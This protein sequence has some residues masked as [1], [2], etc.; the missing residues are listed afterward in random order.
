MTGDVRELGRDHDGRG[1]RGIRGIFH[2]PSHVVPCVLSH[3]QELCLPLLTSLNQCIQCFPTLRSFPSTPVGLQ[4]SVVLCQ[5]SCS[6][7]LTSNPESVDR[8]C[9]RCTRRAGPP[10]PLRR[11]Q[12]LLPSPY[13][14]EKGREGPKQSNGEV[15]SYGVSPT[16]FV[17]CKQKSQD[18]YPASSPTVVP[19]KGHSREEDRTTTGERGTQEYTGKETHIRLALPRPQRKRRMFL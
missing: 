17:V 1:V 18:L 13:R 3:T 7:L 16:T 11:S 4:S 15:L 19:T 14:T 5:Q 10:S 2:S 9:P 12:F 6:R 8:P